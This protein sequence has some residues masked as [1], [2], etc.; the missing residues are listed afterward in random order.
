ME[1]TNEENISSVDRL[2]EI[3]ERLFNCANLAADCETFNGWT[4]DAG[5]LT[6]RDCHGFLWDNI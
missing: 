6:E 2:P 4:I 5:I 1:L 3:G